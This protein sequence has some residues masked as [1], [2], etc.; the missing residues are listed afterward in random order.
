M[1]RQNLLEKIRDNCVIIDGAMGTQLAK[2]GLEPGNCNEYLNIKSPDKVQAIYENY[3][4]AGSDAVITNTFGANTF[5][6][7]R[8]GLSEKVQQIN[9]AAAEIA[10]KAAGPDRYVLGDIGP[11]GD[12]LQPLGTLQPDQLKEA[13]AV[14]AKALQQGGVDAFIIETMSALDE[15][16]IAIEA[17]K[18]VSELPVFASMAYD[19]GQVGYRTMMGVDPENAVEQLT[20]AGVNA[21]GFNCGKM[22]LEDYIKLA[23]IIS[24]KINSLN[25]N[26]F[27]LAE[28]NAG[29]PELTDQGAVYKV[30]PDQ[31]ADAVAKVKDL[32]FKILGGC[33]GTSPAFIKAVAQKLN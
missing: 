5:A 3:F 14:Q 10:R 27:L 31:F 13:F 28:L 4:S 29:I 24:A 20:R 21:L 30:T 11:S 19:S 33:C 25:S 32:G 18:S 23:K 2:A 12:F 7:K 17:V 15:I 16:I 8:H 9:H 26:V 1:Q 22:A 6:L